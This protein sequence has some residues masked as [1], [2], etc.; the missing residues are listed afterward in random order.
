MISDRLSSFAPVVDRDT[1]VLILGTMPSAISLAEG[2]YYANPR[3]QF[4]RL[5]SAVVGAELAAARYEERLA[6]LV[7][8]GV[9]LWD[10]LASAQRHGSLDSAIRNAE[11]NDIAGLASTLPGLS[12][13]AFNGSVAAGHGRRVLVAESARG[14]ITLP[15]SSP[16][17]AMAFE[18]KLAEWMPLQEHLKS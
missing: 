12:L 13:I 8:A 7:A 6:A 14:M 18:R 16:A 17:R 15:S 11:P 5:M 1:R 9:G 10:V 3:N 2:Q 4:W